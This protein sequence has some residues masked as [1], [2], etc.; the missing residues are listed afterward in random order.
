MSYRGECRSVVQLT[1]EERACMSRL[2]LQCYDHSD[3]SRFFKDLNEKQEVILIY[4]E[5]QSEELVGFSSLLFYERLWM[6]KRCGVIYS[7][8]TIVSR[9]H[10]G[11]QALSLTW[12]RRMARFVHE[13]DG[14]PLYWFLLVKGHRTYRY[15]SA[16]F[17]SFHPHWEKMRPDLRELADTLA[18]ERFGKD[19]NPAS[20]VVEFAT[21]QGNL[22]EDLALPTERELMREDVRS[23]FARNPHYQQGHELV[24]LCEVTRENMKPLTR[25]IFERDTL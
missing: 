9:A 24:C 4:H 18:L 7:G 23:F 25:R 10:W 8:D 5:G 22:C 17:H 21:S 20:G 14:I 13:S 12:L 2:Y 16:Y 11:Q 15:L 3:E 19:Y 6:G 1:D